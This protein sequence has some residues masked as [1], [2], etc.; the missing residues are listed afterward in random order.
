[1]YKW[2]FGGKLFHYN[3]KLHLKIN[4]KIKFTANITIETKY[5]TFVQKKKSQFKIPQIVSFYMLKTT[6]NL[7]NSFPKNLQLTINYKGTHDIAGTIPF[8]YF[9]MD[10]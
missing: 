2:Q 5:Y 3:V 7:W 9:S 1:M 10:S 6:N 8:K 4:K